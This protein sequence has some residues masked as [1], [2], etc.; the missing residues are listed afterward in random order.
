[1]GDEA[2]GAGADAAH[3]SG[4]SSR[5]SVDHIGAGPAADGKGSVDDAEHRR[6]SREVGGNGCG[7]EKARSARTHQRP[8]IACRNHEVE[9]TRVALAAVAEDQHAAAGHD[10]LTNKSEV[11]AEHIDHGADFL[12]RN[13]NGHARPKQRG[14]LRASERVDGGDRSRRAETLEQRDGVARLTAAHHL[15]AGIDDAII[16][17]HRESLRCREFGGVRNTVAVAVAASLSKR[18]RRRCSKNHGRSKAAQDRAGVSNGVN[19]HRVHLWFARHMRARHA[20][21]VY[22]LA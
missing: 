11:C 13:N 20:T 6:G 9:Q 2:D 12:L 15:G 4:A 16:H 3:R 8:D 14:K 1:M 18:A 21:S 19:K 7:A 5:R 10:G 22:R 17:A